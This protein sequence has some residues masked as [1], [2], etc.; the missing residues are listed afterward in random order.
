MRRELRHPDVHVL[1]QDRVLPVAPVLQLIVELRG[2]R[3]E[4]YYGT[5]L[6]GRGK[7][8]VKLLPQ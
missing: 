7:R 3:E 4:G 6:T 8:K 2:G 1:V 5:S